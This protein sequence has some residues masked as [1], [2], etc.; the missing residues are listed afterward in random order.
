MASELV[1][2]LVVEDNDIDVKSIRR[3]FRRGSLAN[4]LVVAHDGLE[5]LELLRGHGSGAPLEPPYL[6][7]LDLNMPR[8]GGLEFLEELRGD[9]NLRRTIV[10]VLTTSEDD[11]DKAAA[12]DRQVAAYLSKHDAGGNLQN[13]IELIKQFQTSVHF[14]PPV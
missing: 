13:V 1:K 7:L 9:A 3:A 2:I 12:Y 10:F 5:A 4:A 14:P 8:M 6:V 11:R